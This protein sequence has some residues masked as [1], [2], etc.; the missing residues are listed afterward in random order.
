MIAEKVIRKEL[1]N[2]S[3]QEKMVDG[4][5]DDIKLN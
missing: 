2:K 4:L 5:I 1:S 3:E